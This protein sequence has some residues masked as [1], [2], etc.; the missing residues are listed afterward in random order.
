LLAERVRAALDY[1]LRD[2]GPPVRE[3]DGQIWRANMAAWKE[4]RDSG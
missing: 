3:C 4:A 2:L 1:D